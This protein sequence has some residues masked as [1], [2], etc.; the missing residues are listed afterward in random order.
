ML[1]ACSG[2]PFATVPAGD[3]KALTEMI[4]SMAESPKTRSKLARDSQ[5]Y[6][7]KHLANKV[8][9]RK[10]IHDILLK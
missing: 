3:A 8:V 7:G 9:R 10:L 4:V 2:E 1:Q 5:D 6:Y